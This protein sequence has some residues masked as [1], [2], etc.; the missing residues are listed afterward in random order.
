MREE[1][2]V[3]DDFLYFKGFGGRIYANRCEIYRDFGVFLYKNDV[4]VCHVQDKIV[5][6]QYV[7][8]ME[9]ESHYYIKGEGHSAYYLVTKKM[10]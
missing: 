3:I 10:T 2:K 1:K 4:L 9:S 6:V 7:D 5:D 8:V